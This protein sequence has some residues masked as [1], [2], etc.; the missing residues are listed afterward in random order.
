MTKIAVVSAG[1]SSP[2]ATRVLADQLAAATRL[3]LPGAEVEVIEL[4]PLAHALTDH[5]LTGFPSVQL[6]EALDAVTGADGL[7]AVTPVFTASYSALF[8]AFFDVLD[9]EALASMPVLIAATGGTERHSLALEHAMR[10][11]F[12]YLR[13]HVV[14]TAVYAATS[15]FGEHAG[16]LAE[17]INRA[18]GEFAA[19]I[20]GLG[21]RKPPA[22]EFEDPTPFSQL[23][24]D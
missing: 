7:I 8:K 5:L 20:T 16:A 10:P 14:P 24:S 2:S 11:L 12:G 6:Q 23:L 13:A 9:H 3:A 18:A 17:R 21:P 1:L 15:D 4:R 19:L 22:D